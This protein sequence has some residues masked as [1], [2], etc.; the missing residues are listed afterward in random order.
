MDISPLLVTFGACAVIF[1]ILLHSGARGR[2]GRIPPGTGKSTEIVVAGLTSVNIAGVLGL[3]WFAAAMLVYDGVMVVE[4][5]ICA[6]LIA[7]LAMTTGGAFALKRHR[8]IKA[9]VALLAVAALPA[10]AV[11]GFLLYLDSHPIDMR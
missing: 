11:Y 7:V 10:I 4:L 8:K 5:V 1:A 9:A 3:L 6:V 2:R